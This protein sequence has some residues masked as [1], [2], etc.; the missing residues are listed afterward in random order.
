[1]EG[2]FPV[3]GGSL[4]YRLEKEKAREVFIFL[5]MENSVDSLEVF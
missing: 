5:N 4:I 1:M 2:I 3:V